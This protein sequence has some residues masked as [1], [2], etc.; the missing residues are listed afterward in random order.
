M[1]WWLDL[2]IVEH[3][4]N[5]NLNSAM[6]FLR[7]L[8]RPNVIRTTART[9]Q[10]AAFAFRHSQRWQQSLKTPPRAATYSAAAGLSKE[11]VE[12]RVL[13]V[14][15]GFEKVDPTKVHQSCGQFLLL[16]LLTAF[17]PLPDS[18]PQA[19][20]FSKTWA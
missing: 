4:S 7:A 11:E 9:P 2:V 5:L 10:S 16:I 12:A 3:Q 19:L 8:V 1:R 13:D 14:F 6:T 18:S 20:N 15:K 17:A